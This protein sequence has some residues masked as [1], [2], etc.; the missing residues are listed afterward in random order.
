MS[1]TSPSSKF[2][3]VKVLFYAKVTSNTTERVV[4]LANPPELVF[5]DG[6]WHIYGLTIKANV[7]SLAFDGKPLCKIPLDFTD[8]SLWE[9]IDGYNATDAVL[10]STHNVTG[11]SIL[12]TRGDPP[13]SNKHADGSIIAN[14]TMQVCAELCADCN[15]FDRRFLAR[16][17]RILAAEPLRAALDAR[18]KKYQAERDS[19]R[20]QLTPTLPRLE[21]LRLRRAFVRSVVHEY[22]LDRFHPAVVVLLCACLVVSAG[23]TVV[24]LYLL[25]Q[26]QD[27][28]I[29]REMERRKGSASAASPQTAQPTSTPQPPSTSESHSKHTHPHKSTSPGKKSKKSKQE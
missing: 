6:I 29:L 15:F 25:L 24:A 5:N 28:R 22:L 4:R 12:A 20:A 16:Q 8:S 21:A 10:L 11:V 2:T 1:A 23:L 9:F 17:F 26:E 13:S 19:I 27:K 7:L 3:F 14:N 18:A